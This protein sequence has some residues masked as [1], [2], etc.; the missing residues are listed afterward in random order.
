MKLPID[1]LKKF[2]IINESTQAVADRFYSLGFEVETIENDILDLEITPNRGDALSII[3]LAREYAASTKQ[4]LKIEKINA[5][6]INEH[7]QISIDLKTKEISDYY[8]LIIKNI[9][10]SDSPDWLKRFLRE[11][12]IEPINI[13]VDVTNYIMIEMGLP[14]HAFDLDKINGSKIIFHECENDSKIQT[15]NNNVYNLKEGMVVASDE[16]E[17][18]DLVGLQGGL[19]SGI[20]NETQNILLHGLIINPKNIRK[21]S[22]KLKLSTQASYRYERGVDWQVLKDS[23]NAAAS[24]I[25]QNCQGDI[26]QSYLSLSNHNELSINFDFELIERVSGTSIEKEIATDILNRLEFQVENNLIKVPSFRENDVKLP[27]DIVEEVIRIYGYNNLIKEKL[28]TR[29]G[30]KLLSH[31]TWIR[32]R[33]ASA[34]LINLGFS[35]IM[36]YSFMPAKDGQSNLIKI[37]NPLAPEHTYLRN[38]LT[39]MI[40]NVAESNIWYPSIKIFEIGHI[41]STD[42][43]VTKIALISTEKI[44]FLPTTKITPQD[45]KTR[46]GYYVWEGD[47]DQLLKQI[48]DKLPLHKFKP[49]V[50]K[51]ISKYPPVVRDIVFIVDDNLNIENIRD[52]IF[53]SNKNILLVE[54]F[55]EYRSE[56]IGQNKVSLGFRI[57]IDNI[58]KTMTNEEIDVIINEIISVLNEK[59]SAIFR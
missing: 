23:V 45:N 34:K 42:S 28:P 17:I 8:C 33:Q 50:Y 27:I 9:S 35:E 40:V 32:E 58:D 51:P 26:V 2:V 29:V 10:I 22:K 21:T 48:P 59:F 24:L 14:L 41:Y 15:L 37:I 6:I 36:S 3:G 55:D 12:D 18:I 49:K 39:D 20:N 46:R 43:E 11:V 52:E 5:P 7:E 56:K 1:W 44:N 53:Q 31:E 57:T 54:L 38:N 16:K 4:P 47:I 25:I 30:S 13:V 19:S